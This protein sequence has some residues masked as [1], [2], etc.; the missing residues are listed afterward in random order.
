V[1]V[2]RRLHVSARHVVLLFLCVIAIARA[3]CQDS[4]A[5]VSYLI[6]VKNPAAHLVQ[7]TVSLS[8]FKGPAVLLALS[9]DIAIRFV[10]VESSDGELAITRNGGHF[11]LGLPAG[12]DAR[13]TYE[14]S[15]D[16]WKETPGHGPRGYLCGGYLLSSVAW[17]LLVPDSVPVERFV[18]RF[19]L[20]SGWKAITPWHAAGDGFEETDARLFSGASF[21]AGRFEERSQVLGGTLVRVAVDLRHEEA[22]RASLFDQSFEI[23]SGIKGLFAATGLPN[24]LSIFVKPEGPD[25]WQFL[26][27][28]GSSHGEAVSD[29]RSAAYQHAHRVFHS[30][31]AFYPAGMS[32]EP[33]WFLEGVNEYYC[34]LF[35]AGARVEAPL[36]GLQEIYERTYLPLR[37]RYDAPLAGNLRDASDY[38]REDFLAYKKGALI[39]ALLDLEID[40]ASGGKRSLADVL[41]SLYVRYGSFRG[42]ELT[43][44]VI[45]AEVA[46]TAGRDLKPFFDAYVRSSAPLAMDQLFSDDDLDGICGIGEKWLGTD[47]STFDSDGDLASDACEFWNRTNPLDSLDKP[48]GVVFIDGSGSEWAGLSVVTKGSV[49]VVS[50]RQAVYVRL[51]FPDT[52][53]LV[54]GSIPLRWFLNLDTDGDYSPEL[55]F[56]ALPGSTGDWS[57]F[58]EGNIAYDYQAMLPGDIL[59]AAVAQVAEFRIPWELLG[60]Q[61][62]LRLSAGI[63][64]TTTGSARASVDWM[65]VELERVRQDTVNQW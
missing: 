43:E 34:R 52:A 57:K 30:F 48:L 4:G 45:E 51:S 42:G 56:A 50:D 3:P 18:I 22:F 6:D 17:A 12:G 49:S 25:E 37:A 5:R 53:S 40:K 7:V 36:A 27:E 31:N 55:H 24:H 16:Q 32:I 46:R 28:N 2:Y 19:K 21:A 15:M 60:A 33:T 64:D 14:L 9:P 41:K 29:L 63:W 1:A 20:P 59:A 47:S 54:S 10:K 61:T 23:F 44:A 13:I 8:G 62:P 11:R 65:D 39:A 35:M 26:N 58:G 38:T